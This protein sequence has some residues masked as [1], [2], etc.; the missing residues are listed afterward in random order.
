M[1][2]HCTYDYCR[3]LKIYL[4]QTAPLDDH[5]TEQLI[6]LLRNPSIKYAYAHKRT[7]NMN[8]HLISMRI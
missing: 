3:F 6:V 7:A 5:V 2:W 4:R 1:A 8:E